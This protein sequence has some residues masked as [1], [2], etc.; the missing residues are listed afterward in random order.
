[1]EM[2]KSAEFFSVLRKRRIIVVTSF[3]QDPPLPCVKTFGLIGSVWCSAASC[4]LA[5]I[6]GTEEQSCPGPGPWEDDAHLGGA[7]G[8]GGARLSSSPVPPCPSL[9]R[10]C[11]LELEAVLNG[12]L[13]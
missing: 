13:R 4:G 1:M 5:L 10:N 8:L 9:C 12:M 11:Q 2:R 6:W 7:L 3:A